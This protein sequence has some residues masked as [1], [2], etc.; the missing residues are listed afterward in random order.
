MHPGIRHLVRDQPV[1]PFRITDL[2]P[3]R[4]WQSSALASRMRPDW[5][6]N[7][8]LHIPVGPGIL[9]EES[10]VWVLARTASPFTD[11]DLE[12]ARA[13]TPVLNAVAR[14]LAAVRD[15]KISSE[16]LLLLTPR[17]VAILR[18]ISTGGSSSSVGLQLG[19]SPRTVQ[20]HTEHIRKKLGV[21]SRTDAALAFKE[22]GL[23]SS[24]PESAHDRPEDATK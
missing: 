21:R 24:S 1:D 6:R 23:G 7:Q 14:H 13:I 5:G 10:Q 9:H 12:V 20:K 2:V 4:I 17:E 11:R 19:I 3:D 22:L 15:L 18:L 16:V 8:Q